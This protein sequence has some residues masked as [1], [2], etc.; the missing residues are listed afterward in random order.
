MNIFVTGV[1]SLVDSLNWGLAFLA[2]NPERQE[3]IHVEIAR[4]MGPACDRDIKLEDMEK[5]KR[6][7]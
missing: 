6:F 4:V 5:Y 3:K 1:V 2:S 7:C